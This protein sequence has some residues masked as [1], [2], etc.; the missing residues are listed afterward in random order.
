M[1]IIDAGLPGYYGDID[2]ELALMGRAPTDVRALVRRVAEAV[3]QIRQT[4]G[5][6]G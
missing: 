1:T 6:S 3:Q 5:S 2:L 4:Q